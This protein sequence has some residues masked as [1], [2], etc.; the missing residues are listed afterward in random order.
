MRTYPPPTDLNHTSA[1]IIDAFY[2]AKSVLEQHEHP[3]VSISGGRDSDIMMDIVWRLVGDRATYLFFDTGIEWQESKRQVRR[4]EE[5]YGVEVRRVT[6]ENPVPRIVHRRGQPFL[7]KVVSQCV[8]ALQSA[9]F[10]WS[11]RPVDELVS[12]YPKVQG[13]IR[14]WC[15]D[16]RSGSTMSSWCV[17][18]HP[19]LRRF[20]MEHPPT[21]RIS[22]RCCHFSKKVTAAKVQESGEFDLVCTGVRKAEGGVRSV[23]YANCFTPKQPKHVAAYRPVF[24]FSNEDER[25]YTDYF[26]LRHSDCYTVWG[27]CRTGC[28]GCPF[29]FDFDAE[30]SIAQYYEPQMCKVAH[31]LFDASYEYTR[32][33]RDFRRAAKLP[34]LTLDLL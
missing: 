9:G 18:K 21:F 22:D 28:A 13:Y 14:W 3:C 32:A 8:G 10:D 16:Y 15:N 23:R 19:L 6:A 25:I 33:Y 20:I 11:D 29:S 7:S 2:K 27:L 4:L 26:G 31:H 1:M 30:L 34:N 12:R 24:W 5:R 17:D